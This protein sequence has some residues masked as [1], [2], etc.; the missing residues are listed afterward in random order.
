MGFDYLPEYGLSQEQIEAFLRYR[1]MLL[2]W[3]TQINLTA[4][5]DPVEIEIKHFYDSLVL[6]NSAT[7]ASSTKSDPEKKKAVHLRL[8]DVGGGAGF[9]GI[10]LKLVQTNLALDT[11][12]A[13]KKK[14][15]FLTALAQEM[16]LD[17]VRAL[18]L[19]AEEAGQD[20]AYRG[21]YDW[22]LARGVAT[23][24]VLLEYCLP[25]LRVGAYFAA[26]KGPTGKA[27]ALDGAKAEAVLGGKL[28][29]T[30]EAALPA[31]QG[32]RM[33]LIYQKIKE[34]PKAYPRRPGI[35]AKEAIR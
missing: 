29:E 34:T 14:V 7:W 19:R 15:G 11:L 28:V 1:E 30:V 4:I 22:V 25:L 9:P 13:S 32:E 20:R 12:E 35:P 26:Y 23:M 31:G 5:T 3:N 10:P 2:F 17:H 6:V 16:Q 27:E 8:A 24:P 33:I 21:Q 18:H